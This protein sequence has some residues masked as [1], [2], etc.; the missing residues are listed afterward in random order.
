MKLNIAGRCV[1]LG[2]VV[3]HAQ[4]F[5]AELKRMAS[6]DFGYGAGRAVIVIAVYNDTAGSLASESAVRI[7]TVYHWYRQI[8]ENRFGVQRGR[9]SQTSKV[10]AQSRGNAIVV[11]AL[12]T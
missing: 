6:L 2:V 10:I 1:G 9:P 8:V 11:E 5:S 7:E 3:R 12:I 4:E